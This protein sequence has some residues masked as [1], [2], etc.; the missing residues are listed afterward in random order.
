[1]D[2]EGTPFEFAVKMKQFLPD[3]ELHK[4]LGTGEIDGSVISQLAHHIGEFHSRIEPAGNTSS[5]GEPDRIWGAVEEC[6]E[7]IPLDAFSLPVQNG[8][9]EIK[10][11]TQQEWVRLSPVFIQRK[12][13]GHIRECHGDLHLGNIALFRG[14]D[15]CV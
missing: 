8:L 5:Y 4:L 9:K 7:E 13:S 12:S 1:M 6:F 2:G 14:P 15:L 11:W 3:H 10:K